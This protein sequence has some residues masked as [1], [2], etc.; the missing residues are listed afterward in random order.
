MG[1]GY[2][3]IVFEA[4]SEVTTVNEGVFLTLAPNG[5]NGLRALGCLEPVKADGIDTT[6]IEILNAKGKR[7]GLAD[8]RACLSTKGIRP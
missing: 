1:S 6:G 2:G 8:L 3:A 7:L 5:T 4:R